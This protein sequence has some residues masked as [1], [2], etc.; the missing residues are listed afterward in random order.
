MIINSHLVNLSSPVERQIPKSRNY[1]CL[2]P[3]CNY[4]TQSIAHSK[5][6]GRSCEVKEMN[7]YPAQRNADGDS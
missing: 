7:E 4:L 5:Y 3:H 1:V 6:S 2:I